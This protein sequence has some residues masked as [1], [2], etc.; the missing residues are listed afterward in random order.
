[1]RIA[2]AGQRR[3]GLGSGRSRQGLDSSAA[4]SGGKDM[5]TARVD[6]SVDGGGGQTQQQPLGSVVLGL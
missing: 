4:S 1:M 5:E 2:R 3:H 6:L